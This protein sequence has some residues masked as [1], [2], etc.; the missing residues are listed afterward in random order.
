M[1]TTPHLVHLQ[2]YRSDLLRRQKEYQ[3]AIF[4][5]ES[6]MIVGAGMEEGDRSTREHLNQMSL[7]QLDSISR[8]INTI[9]RALQMIEAGTYGI[10]SACDEDIDE[11]R[12]RSLPFATLCLDC[13]KKAD[14]AGRQAREKCAA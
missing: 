4:S 3:T 12:L 1:N 8:T 14:I 11:Q 9:D 6:K 13:Q 2:S 7:L 5:E 10:C